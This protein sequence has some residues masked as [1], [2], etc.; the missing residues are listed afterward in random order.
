MHKNKKR[1]TLDEIKESLENDTKSDIQ[2]N[3]E[4]LD[5][6]IFQLKILNNNISKIINSLPNNI[7]HQSSYIS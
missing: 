4:K 2:I 6:I 5:E 1:F 3:N 7:N